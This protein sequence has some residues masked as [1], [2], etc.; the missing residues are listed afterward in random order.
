MPKRQPRAAVDHGLLL[1][2]AGVGMYRTLLHTAKAVAGAQW[3]IAWRMALLQNAAADLRRAGDPEFSRMVAEKAE[4]AIAVAP[5]M[6]SS[7]A[8]TQ[9]E[10][11]RIWQAEALALSPALSRVAV[12]GSPAAVQIVGEVTAEAADRSISAGLNLMIA[13]T[14]LMAAALAP[15]RRRI[16]GNVKRLGG[17]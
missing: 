9:M 14:R 4:A 8:R 3:V 6:A 2:R 16:R 12:S 5:A 7:W 15:Y 11:L 1:A 10:L 17:A 13:N